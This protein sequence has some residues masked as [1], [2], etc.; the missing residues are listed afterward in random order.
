MPTT[1]STQHPVLSPPNDDSRASCAS[2]DTRSATRAHDDHGVTAS[3]IAAVADVN[4]KTTEMKSNRMETAK[5]CQMVSTGNVLT[6]ASSANNPVEKGS[7]VSF[8]MPPTTFIASSEISDT[9][10]STYENETILESACDENSVASSSDESEEAVNFIDTMDFI[11]H[12]D[13]DLDDLGNM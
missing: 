11:S 4:L 3:F 6:N 8:S 10:F 7:T 9:T 5:M 2:S 1:I 13:D 12:E